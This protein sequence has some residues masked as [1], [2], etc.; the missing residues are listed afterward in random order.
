MTDLANSAETFDIVIRRV[1]VFDGYDALPGLRDVG[2]R[3]GVIGA[4]SE[5][6]LQGQREIDGMG[7]WVMPASSIP[8]C[9]SSTSG[10]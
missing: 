2:L 6:P 4:V 7:G 10:W 1:R 3:G 5:A 8:T 9:T